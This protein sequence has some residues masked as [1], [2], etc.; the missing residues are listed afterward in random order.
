MID[1]VH[2]YLTRIGAGDRGVQHCRRPNGRANHRANAFL[3][4]TA[5]NACAAGLTASTSKYSSL[6]FPEVML[7]DSPKPGCG[8]RLK[9]AEIDIDLGLSGDGVAVFVCGFES[10]LE[11]GFDSYFVETQAEPLYDFGIDGVALFINDDVEED[12]SLESGMASFLGI[13]GFDLVKE[14]RS[15]NGI[16]VVLDGWVISVF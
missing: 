14:L 8:R 13:V 7:T 4:N 9:Q 11:D 3:V 5:V 10:P 6:D 2:Q 16:D 15:G 1:L 12:S